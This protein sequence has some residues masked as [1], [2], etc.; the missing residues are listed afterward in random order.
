M[1]HPILAQSYLELNHKLQIGG[2]NKEH[3]VILF[4]EYNFIRSIQHQTNK[5]EA[6][7]YLILYLKLS[8]KPTVRLNTK[9]PGFEF[10]STQKYPLRINW[11]WFPT[12]A[13]S[14]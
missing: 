14:R 1:R 8:F 5:F 12:S 13:F 10:L 2:A 11:K 6:R 3:K 4:S 9:A 7:K